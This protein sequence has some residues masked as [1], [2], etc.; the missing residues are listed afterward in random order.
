VFKLVEEVVLGIVGIFVENQKFRIC[1]GRQHKL[2]EELLL[3]L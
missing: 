3:E 1:N 2:V